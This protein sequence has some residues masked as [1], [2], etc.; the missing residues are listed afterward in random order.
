MKL[1]LFKVLFKG[2]GRVARFDIFTYFSTVC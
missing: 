1:K 2:T